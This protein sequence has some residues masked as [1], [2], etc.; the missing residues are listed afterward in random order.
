VD[1][2]AAITAAASNKRG[3]GHHILDE[4]H[5]QQASLVGKHQIMA[6]LI[7]WTPGHRDITG[8]E[9]ADM[10]A[11]KATEGDTSAEHQLPKYLRNGL[12]DSRSA[13]QQAFNAKLKRLAAKV[14]ERSPRYQ[15]MNLMVPGLPS[16]SYFNSIAKLPR[17][18]T[19]IITQLITG[20]APLNK[21]L[22]RIGKADSATCPCCHEHEETITHFL[23]HCPVHQQA[24]ALMMAEIP[25][26]EQNLAGFLA[27]HENRK[28]LLNFVSR[29]TR[30]RAVFGTLA[31]LQEQD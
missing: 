17:K 10:A 27:T 9:A 2:Q 30:F 5:R 31:Q 18:H 8:N 20:H 25:V 7:R 26:D 1:S 21:H 16:A 28:Q 19:S 22:H 12:P 29:T 13:V 11:R 23:L 15:R 14:W 24:R 3:P 4:F 6:M